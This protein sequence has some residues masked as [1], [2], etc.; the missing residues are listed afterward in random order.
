MRI[1]AYYMDVAI[2]DQL[3]EKLADFEKELGYN[4]EA[5]NADIFGVDGVDKDCIGIMYHR[6]EGGVCKIFS[7]RETDCMNF[8][9]SHEAKDFISKVHSKPH[10][11]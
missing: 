3:K 5:Y 10:R 9:D 11:V 7:G 1:D 2:S 4:V 6:N 8:L